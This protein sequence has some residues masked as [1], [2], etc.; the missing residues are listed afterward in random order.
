MATGEEKML[1]LSINE[2][3]SNNA[4]QNKHA[5]HS[6]W[7][8]AVDCLLACFGIGRLP[9]PGVRPSPVVSILCQYEIQ[10]VDAHGG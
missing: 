8:Q 9:T 7:K 4:E 1:R 3:R 6:Q 10:T 5:V 2:A